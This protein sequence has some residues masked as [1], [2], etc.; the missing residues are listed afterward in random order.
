[1][2]ELNFNINGFARPTTRAEISA[3]LDEALRLADELN[4]HLSSMEAIMEAKAQRVST[5]A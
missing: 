2:N 1:M 3:L 4:S 5:S